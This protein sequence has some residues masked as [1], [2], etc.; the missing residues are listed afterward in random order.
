MTALDAGIGRVIDQVDTLGLSDNTLLM[1]A[2]DNGGRRRD[3]EVA[4]NAPFRG[5][6]TEVYEGG[7]RTPCIIRWSVRVPPSSVCQEP[8]TN[9]D[10]F[11]LFLLMRLILF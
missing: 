2:S 4:T 8:L 10:L 9:M 3:L 1:V 7:I 11:A 5:V 6:R